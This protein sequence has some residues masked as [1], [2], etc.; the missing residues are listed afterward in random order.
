MPNPNITPIPKHVIVKLMPEQVRDLAITLGAC[1][2]EL[3]DVPEFVV[4]FAANLTEVVAMDEGRPEGWERP[5]DGESL[6]DAA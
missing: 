2:R 3:E 4:Q 6:A 5:T 1:V